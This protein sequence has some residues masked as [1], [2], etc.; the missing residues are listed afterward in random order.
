MALE[1]QNDREWDL[2]G[3]VI[4]GLRYY[5]RVMLNE[6]GKVLSGKMYTQPVNTGRSLR[7]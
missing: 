3:S 4:N 2:G 6:D 5:Y 7:L 1:K